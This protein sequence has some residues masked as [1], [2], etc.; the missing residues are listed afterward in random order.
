MS[1]VPFRGVGLPQK[2]EAGVSA[3]RSHL[4]LQREASRTLP[5]VPLLRLEYAAQ[6]GPLSEVRPCVEDEGAPFG[7]CGFVLPLLRKS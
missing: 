3:V 7:R 6:G 1:P 4:G 2:S 5:A